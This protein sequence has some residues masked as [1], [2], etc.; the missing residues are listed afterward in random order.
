MTDRGL[1]RQQPQHRHDLPQRP[2]HPRPRRA[3]RARRR[4][5]VPAA[6]Q[7]PPP[8]GHLHP[9]RPVL[10][11]GL[12]GRRRHRRPAAGPHPAPPA[13][14]RTAASACRP[15]RCRSCSA[16]PERLEWS[17]HGRCR[18]MLPMDVRQVEVGCEF[19]YV[20]EVPTPT[21][22]QVQPRS[23]SPAS[24]LSAE[25]S[26]EP[27][28]PVRSY[29]D[30][31]GNPCHRLVVPAGRSRFR[32]HAVVSVPDATEDV[33]PAHPSC[34]PDAAAR[35]RAALHPAQPLLPARH[36]RRRGVVAL[37]WLPPGYRR[38]QAICDYVHGHLQFRYGSTT[39]LSTAADVNTAGFR[40]LPR[41]HPSGHLVL[42]RPE[43][44]RPLRVRLPPGH[45]R[46]A[47]Q[48]ADGL[49]RVDGGLARRPLV[50]VRPPQQPPAQ[51]PGG[52]RPRPGRLGCGHGHDLRR[53]AVGVDDGAGSG[54]APGTACRYLPAGPRG[55]TLSR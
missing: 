45:G 1:G 21:V 3:R 10:R 11:A 31:Y 34:R 52:H 18:N 2:G 47:D 4:R 53:S 44:P 55:V 46:R 24:V 8:A 27:D 16:A 29:T 35:R 17:G 32:Y 43:H 5:L 48:R 37:R 6:D 7:R 28:T 14:T 42:P 41:L 36:A 39:S 20:A 22:F 19:S 33:D 15:A 26:V 49:R 38:V 40:G 12:G 23:E 9:A 30:L 51:G 13:R 54:G 25:T 50:D